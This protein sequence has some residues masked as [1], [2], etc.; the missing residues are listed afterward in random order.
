[1]REGSELLVDS[2]AAG[3]EHAA[4]ADLPRQLRLGRLGD[5]VLPD[6]T[7]QP[8]RQVQ[9]LGCGGKQKRK[10]APCG[11]FDIFNIQP[12]ARFV[13]CLQPYR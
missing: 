4:A 2:Q 9:V 5:V 12:Y 6:L 8:V 1:M 7:V 13:N 11:A 3:A 10:N